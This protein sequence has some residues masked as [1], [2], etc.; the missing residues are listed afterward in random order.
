MDLLFAFNSGH[1]TKFEE[2][3]SDWQGQVCNTVHVT[4]RW[5]ELDLLALMDKGGVLYPNVCCHGS[6]VFDRLVCMCVDGTILYSV[7]YRFSQVVEYPWPSVCD[8]V[9]TAGP[10]V[11]RDSDEA[12]DLPSL[13]NGGE[14]STLEMLNTAPHNIAR[15]LE[16]SKIF[17]LF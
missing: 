14:A 11:S 4:H 8:S 9:I 2:L 16:I 7:K 17:F 12:E 6:S 10:H 3:R 15:Q 13:L 5:A 1:I